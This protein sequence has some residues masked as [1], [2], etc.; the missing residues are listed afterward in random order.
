MQEIDWKEVLIIE[1]RIISNSDRK[2][3][4]HF[5]SLDVVNENWVYQLNSSRYQYD[6]NVYNDDYIN[7]VNNPILAKALKTLTSKQ[8]QVV[9]LLYWDGYKGY[10][11]ARIMQ[12]TPA[13][14]SVILKKALSNIKQFLETYS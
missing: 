7:T 5:V 8:S 11:I 3:R 2:H 12:C 10:E 4:A 13:N 14:V 1:D 9:K 6:I